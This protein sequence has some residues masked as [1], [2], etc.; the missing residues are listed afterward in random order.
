MNWLVF[1][2]SLEAL[3]GASAN[4]WDLTHNNDFTLLESPYSL[5]T[6]R[7]FATTKKLQND[8]ESSVYAKEY[9]DETAKIVEKMTDAEKLLLLH[10][11]F[12]EYT[13]KI[14]GIPRLGL[15]PLYM[16]DVSLRTA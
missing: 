14:P 15:P 1:V 10:G 9:Q 8:D 7:D 16:N 5:Q 13:G 6:E 4:L 12:S 3:S 2:L 11:T